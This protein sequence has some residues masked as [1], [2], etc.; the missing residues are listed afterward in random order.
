MPIRT[1]RAKS[2]M[3][4]VFKKEAKA[5]EGPLNQLGQEVF[6]NAP[7][8]RE[9][10]RPLQTSLQGKKLPKPTRGLR[11]NKSGRRTKVVV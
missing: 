11:F 5:T 1:K 3:K 8:L 6:H 9:G 10:L 2:G 4:R 7:E